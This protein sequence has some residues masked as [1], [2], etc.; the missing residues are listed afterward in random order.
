MPTL[1][2][3]RHEQFARL[4]AAGE[5]TTKAYTLAGYGDVNAASCGS[6]LSKTAKVHSRIV[7]LGEESARTAIKRVE[8]NKDWV[9]AKLKENVER[10]MQAI[11]VLDPKGNPTGKYEWNGSVANR[12]LE[13]IGKHLGM[14]R[15]NMDVTVKGDLALQ[16]EAKIL[17]ATFTLKQLEVMMTAA[18]R[19][20]MANAEKQEAS[21]TAAAI[22]SGE[23]GGIPVTAEVVHERRPKRDE[24]AEPDIPEW[25]R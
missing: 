21:A 16:H 4:V 23:D 20:V 24:L 2:N 5:T 19:A 15:E 14:F 10:A 25:M 18:E 3:P 8:L 17:A 11:P 13:L 1:N 7:E 12:G 22:S 6:R 9:L